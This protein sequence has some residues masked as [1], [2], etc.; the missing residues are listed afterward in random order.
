MSGLGVFMYQDKKQ[1]N[2]RNIYPREQNDSKI[3]EV[4][5]NGNCKDLKGFD[6]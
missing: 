6:R 1:E 3:M 2:D 5:I 4:P